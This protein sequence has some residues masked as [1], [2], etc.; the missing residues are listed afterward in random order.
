MALVVPAEIGHAPYAVPLLSYLVGHFASVHVVALR[1][2]AFPYLSEDTWILYAD[3]FGN[4]SQAITFSQSDEFLASAS[5][6]SGGEKIAFSDW[7]NWR[8]RLR[9]FLLPLETR[10]LYAHLVR[11]PGVKRL[12]ALAR[13]GI[14]YVT[15]AN[16]FFHLRPSVARS[17]RIPDRFLR[18][19]VRNA[20]TLPPL[21]LT[22][23]TTEAWVRRD[24]P[25]LLLHLPRG[26][27]LPEAVLAY[28]DSPAGQEAKGSYKCR[29]RQPWYAVPDV[30]VPDGFL[31]YMSGEGPL[32]VAN[33][34][35][36]T[37]TNSLHAV[38]LKNEVTFSDLQTMWRHPLARL[39]CELEGH[40][41][42]GGL[43]KLEPKEAARVV[44]PP[45]DLLLS[46]SETRLL[47]EGI[48]TMRRWRHYE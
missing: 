10:R 22:A 30:R 38:E 15:G 27:E 37:C 39:S 31:S 9:P 20:R 35:G 28:L 32:L 29:N 24:E 16:D 11:K 3:G 17:A 8:Y 46:R 34:A 41:L 7:K 33:A 14:G 13:V 1:K 42:G 5:P 21:V 12:D 36:C 25:V 48:R 19:T 44:M 40:P 2:K 43:L 45:P 4:E 6:P 18:F 26:Q 23:Q 47:E